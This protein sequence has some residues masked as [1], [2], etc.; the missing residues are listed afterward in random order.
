MGQ[1]KDFTSILSIWR[2]FFLHF[3]CIYTNNHNYSAGAAR[4]RRKLCGVVTTSIVKRRGGGSFFQGDLYPQR[5][6][7]RSEAAVR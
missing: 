4:G 3:I 2:T 1:V 6:S 7:I 5:N